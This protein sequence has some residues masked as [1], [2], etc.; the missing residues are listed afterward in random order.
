MSDEVEELRSQMNQLQERVTELERRLNGD[1]EP[2]A[3]EGI[4]EFVESFDPSSHTERSLSIAYYLET[5]RDKEK[6][7]VSDIEDGYRECRVK[8][9]SNMSDVLGRMEGRDWLLRDGT[10][11]QTQ[12]WRLTA[13][14]LEIVEEE[15]NNGA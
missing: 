7:T 8:P 13:T 14:A 10:N 9:A 5:Y 3:A 6:F 11:G 2:E 12:L 4:R 15:L 1:E